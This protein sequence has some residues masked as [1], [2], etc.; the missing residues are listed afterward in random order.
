[1]HKFASHKHISR[2]LCALV[3]L[4]SFILLA[5][6][7]CN[8]KFLDPTQIGRFRPVP[9]VNV[10][11]DTLG[12]SEET[13]ASWETGEEPKPADVV[14]YETDYT[15]GPG[16]VVLINIFELFNEGT[17][18]SNQFVVTETGRISIPDVG[19]VE[20][21]GLT[22]SQLEEEIK[23]I[24]SPNL[25]KNPSVNVVLLQSQSRMFSIL[26]TGVPKPGRYALPRYDFRLADALAT[27]GGISQFNISYVYVSRPITGKESLT[28]PVPGRVEA[29][30]AAEPPAAPSTKPALQT[31]GEQR[32]Q[33]SR[34]LL[35][36]RENK[37]NCLR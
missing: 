36:H 35:N 4:C 11:L 26:G 25:L 29:A 34:P 31:E 19:V 5:A 15:F 1:M 27:A 23:Q 32:L 9:A 18:Y 14:A 6:T 16:D 3:F 22:E 30:P 17:M 2:N 24:L 37:M 28:E 13:T 12:V 33:L 8:D 20:A 21:S 7:G 10:I